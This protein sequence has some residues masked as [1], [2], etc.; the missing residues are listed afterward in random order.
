MPET[1]PCQKDETNPFV[2]LAGHA[3]AIAKG[4][5]F[6]KDNDFENAA[7]SYEEAERFHEAGECYEQIEAYEEAKRCYQQSTYQSEKSAFQKVEAAQKAQDS[8]ERNALLDKALARLELSLASH[9]A[10]L[11]LKQLDPNYT[12]NNLDTLPFQREESTKAFI[13]SLR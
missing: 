13:E 2:G 10:Y 1:L 7:L 8:K 9:E 6:K 11:R 4:K 3:L 12:E 5:E